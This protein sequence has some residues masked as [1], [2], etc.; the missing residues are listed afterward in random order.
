M[1]KTS[2]GCMSLLKPLEYLSKVMTFS[3]LCGI[4]CPVKR[5]EKAIFNIDI[6]I[7]FTRVVPKYAVI[8]FYH[9]PLN[10]P[11]YNLIVYTEIRHRSYL[12]YSN[13][14]IA[15]ILYHIIPSSVYVYYCQCHVMSSFSCY[16]MLH[17]QY[18]YKSVVNFFKTKHSAAISKG[19]PSRSQKNFVCICKRRF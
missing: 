8:L 13:E 7:Y 19:D 11:N 17:F 1:L 15:Q 2:S 10:S 6:I 4:K 12:F 3:H 18:L 14:L 9:F 16:V 5:F